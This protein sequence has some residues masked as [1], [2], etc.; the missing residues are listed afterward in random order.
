MIYAGFSAFILSILVPED[1]WKKNRNDPQ[2]N[3][4]QKHV[5]CSYGYKIVCVDDKFIKRFK[6]L[7]RKNAVD[8]FIS[9]MVEESKY[10]PVVIKKTF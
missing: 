2:N 1:N 4:Y 10:Y 3:K 5:T 8:N 9:S 6:S 7:L